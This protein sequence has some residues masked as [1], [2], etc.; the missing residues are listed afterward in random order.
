M[1]CAPPR[2]LYI[3]RQ[4]PAPTTARRIAGHCF[5]MRARLLDRMITRIYDEA[6]RPHGLR[7]TQMTLLVGISLAE[8]A[9][10]GD[11]AL[12]FEMDKSTMSRNVARL[13]EAG[14]VTTCATD[15]RGHALSVTDDG[16]ALLE[17][18]RPAWEGAQRQVKTL[19]GAE[20][21][22]GLRSLPLDVPT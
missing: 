1:P 17:E 12:W 16:R 4:V 18:I 14:W 8:P 6:M 5:A 15:G 20:L 19:L 2:S 9:R 10:P 13:V 22:E 11:L 7:S 21:V 3:Q